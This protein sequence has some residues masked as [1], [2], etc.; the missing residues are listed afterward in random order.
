MRISTQQ[1]FNTSLRSMLDQQARLQQ[2]EQQIASGLRVLKPS[3]DP[4]AAVRSVNLE[5][6][7]AVIKQYSSNAAAAES[8]LSLEESV[9]GNVGNIL[10]RARELNV[11]AVNDTN[12]PQSRAAIATEL[13]ERLDEL[14]S[15]ANT[16]D[17]A[18]EYIFGGYSV[19]AQPFVASGGSASYGGDQGQRLLQVGEGTQVAVRDSGAE[20]FELIP[21]GNGRI[22]ALPDGANTGTLVVGAYSAGGNYVPDNYTISFTQ[23]LPTDPIT[24]SV[25]DGGGPPVVVASGTWQ[26]GD[27]IQFNGAQ[28]SFSGVPA[29]G[30]SVTVTD[31]GKRSVFDSLDALASALEMSTPSGVSS[32]QQHNAMNRALNELDQALT[33]VNEVRAAVGSRLN[34]VDSQRSINQ[35]F[36]LQLQTALSEN[37]DLDYAEAISRFNSQLTSLQA[38]QQAYVKVQELSL[39]KF[40]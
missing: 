1:T 35:D 15:L 24:Y 22:E 29:D 13:R 19:G 34:I 5:G 7:I 20:V 37:R 2:S 30:D 12:S 4:S 6:N 21:S 11:Q 9:L 32:A 36:D 23:A 31:A 18:G 8:Q 25:T 10:Q 28:L 16:R 39:F 38:A 17:A 33:H 26:V 3:D 14:L 27:D 40:L